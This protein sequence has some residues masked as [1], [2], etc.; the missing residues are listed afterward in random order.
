MVDDQLGRGE[1][2]DLLRIA[3]ELLHGI[4]HGGEVDD[5]GHAGEVLHDDARGRERDLVGGRRLGVP[6]EQRLDVGARDVHAVF[7][8][9]Q[10][11]EQDLERVGQARDFFGGQGG[12]A[13]VVVGA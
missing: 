10:V 7:E 2:V 9:Q 4:A 1:R 5:A 3:A 8:A 13:P 12:E 11:L 6:V